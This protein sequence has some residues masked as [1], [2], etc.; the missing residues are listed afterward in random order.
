MKKEMK[1]KHLI[2][3]LQKC[4]KDA[5]VETDFNNNIWIT[6]KKSKSLSILRTVI[7]DFEEG[8]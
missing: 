4:D 5:K 6:D 7:R 3:I 1:V 8:K 2:E